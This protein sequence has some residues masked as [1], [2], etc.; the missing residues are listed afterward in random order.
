MPPSTSH[1]DELKH[2]E[3]P[4]PTTI[5]QSGKLVA[6]WVAERAAS[7][8]QGIA[9][10]SGSGSVTYE[11][12]NHRANQLAYRLRALGV[13]AEVVVAICLERSVMAVIAA[14]AILK[15]GGAY[16]PLDSSAPPER[17]AFILND[18]QPAAVI[19]QSRLTAKVGTG[20]WQV[21]NLDDVSSPFR[22]QSDDVPSGN[23]TPANLA[24]V[25][26][27]SGSTGQPKGVQVTHSG[28]TN[29]VAWHVNAFGVTAADRATQL[30]SLGFDAAVWE[31]WAHLSVGASLYIVPEDVRVSPELLRD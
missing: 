30:A 3:G 11:E 26:Y 6:T 19:T 9:V 31:M 4:T 27:T 1:V 29:L 7:T 22:E 21:V 20:S 15:A 28:L 24:Y 2:R 17:L 5:I 13:G 16:L 25:I 12:L 10:V 23:V 18:A 14:L 8:P